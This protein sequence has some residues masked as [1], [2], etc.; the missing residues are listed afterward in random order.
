MQIL[1]MLALVLLAVLIVAT[2]RRRRDV[3]LLT[4]KVT[5]LGGKPKALKRIRKGSPFPDTGRG[6]WSWRV[7]WQDQQTERQSW[8][9]TTRE[10]MSDWRD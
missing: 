3:K 2:T 7:I 1:T 8:A 9:L 5:E 6:W 10:G 4:E